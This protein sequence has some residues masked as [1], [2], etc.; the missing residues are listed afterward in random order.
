MPVQPAQPLRAGEEKADD[1]GEPQ[2]VQRPGDAPPREI[3][4]AV[5]LKEETA[6]PGE[7]SGDGGLEQRGR[8]LGVAGERN[9]GFHGSNKGG[10]SG[11]AMERAGRCDGVAGPTPQ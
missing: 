10:R 3:G 8:E 4:L 6:Q 5:T 9:R 1:G 11:G 7:G 2:E